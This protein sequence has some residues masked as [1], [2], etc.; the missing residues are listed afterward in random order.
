ML[1]WLQRFVEEFRFV[2][3]EGNRYEYIVNGLFVTI[4]VSIAAVLLGIAL[5]FLLAIMRLT[6]VRKG[7][8][9]V[10]SMIASVYI[11]IVRG[12]PAVL[13]LL[14][15]YF[16]VFKSQMGVVAA[17]LSFGMN[18]AA[19]V[20]EI[21]RAGIMAVDNGQ[22]EAGRSLGLSYGLTMRYVIVP[23]AVKNILPA[24]GNEFIQLIKETSILGY[25]SIYDL[26]KA[27]NYIT[28]R[29]YRMFLPLIATGVI[30]YVLT[31]VLSFGIG[32]M[33]R[34]LRE[35]DQG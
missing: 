12:T 35:S 9:T 17:I 23:Q 24:L 8:K 14:I 3:I 15:M 18:S 34:R 16:V 20:S 33:E 22:M 10:L 13:Q 29:T 26:T 2:F 19:Y 28:S 32:K 11:D 1:Q 31:K 30:Y 25:I 5:G 7:K 4:G 6:E 21:M 27:A